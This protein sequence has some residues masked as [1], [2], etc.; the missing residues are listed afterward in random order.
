M[1]ASSTQSST[2]VCNY[3]LSLISAELIN[4]IDDPSSTA[5]QCKQF[6]GIAYDM[7]L[8]S[9]Q[10]HEAVR[11]ASLPSDGSYSVTASA[12]EFAYRYKLPEDPYLLAL[13]KVNEKDVANVTGAGLVELQGRSLLTNFE[14]PVFIR[15][16]ARLSDVSLLPPEIHECVAYQVAAKM[17]YIKHKDNKRQRE[18]L[19]Q[20]RE[21]IEPAAISLRNSIGSGYEPIRESAFLASYI[22]DTDTLPVAT[23]YLG[24]DPT[25]PT[26]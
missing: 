22:R 2:Q 6:F 8:R 10:P 11:T 25:N 13:L 5:R 21:I 17:A 16:I 1:S 14:A 15:Y 9:V 18:L 26:T 19:L 4:S 3:A 20:Y 24:P 23:G 7:V 12:Y